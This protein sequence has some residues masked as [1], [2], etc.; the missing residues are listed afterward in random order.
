MKNL[1]NTR[2]IAAI[3]LAAALPTAA[4]ANLVTHDSNGRSGHSTAQIEAFSQLNQPL[5]TQSAHYERTA[6]N[7]T[8]SDNEGHSDAVAKSFN[9][10]A[11]QTDVE[12]H[13]T[14]NDDGQNAIGHSSSW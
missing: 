13:F 14:N 7:V 10:I 6:Q 2:V 8:V 1:L 4:Q 3:A 5:D 9:Q 12:T 11:S